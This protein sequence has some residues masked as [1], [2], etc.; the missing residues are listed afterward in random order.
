MVEVSPYLNDYGRLVTG[1]KDSLKFKVPSLRNVSITYPYM[2]DGR[3]QS[4]K[5]VLNITE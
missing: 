5:A 1:K 3:Y 4:L 2:H